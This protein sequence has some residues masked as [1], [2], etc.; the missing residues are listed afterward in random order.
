VRARADAGL[1][2]Y[3]PIKAVHEI[4]NSCRM[5]VGFQPTGLEP[6]LCEVF[7]PQRIGDPSSPGGQGCTT[8]DTCFSQDPSYACSWDSSSCSCDCYYVG[9]R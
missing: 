2:F 6:G 4:D 8:V 3:Y 9:P 5:A 7:I 1:E